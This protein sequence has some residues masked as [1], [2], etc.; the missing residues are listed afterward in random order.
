M[1]EDETQF[2]DLSTD[3][4]IAPLEEHDGIDREKAQRSACLLFEA[5]GAEPDSNPYV[6]TRQGRMPA[7]LETLSEGAR[8]EEKPTLRKYEST[9]DE[10]VVKTDIPVYSLC[11]L[12]FL[13]YHGTAHVAYRASE[14][15][16]WLSKLSRS[17]RWQSRQLTI[18]EQLTQVIADGLADELDT[19]T[20]LVELSATHLC[21]AMRGI[22]TA[23][24]TT[25][26]A[27]FGTPTSAERQRFRD[28]IAHAEGLQ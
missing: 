9:S 26:R 24:E 20:V 21:E 4:R 27:I 28:A 12:H 8:R 3:D 23:T 15:V 22:E 5:I 18:Q 17:M 13:P 19:K 10:L 7:M 11:Q 25:T 2:S 14:E 1:T 6:E 16:V